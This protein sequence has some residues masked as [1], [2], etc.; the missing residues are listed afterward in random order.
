META[1][2]H[3]RGH[4]GRPFKSHHS[5]M[6]T[7]L[8][9]PAGCQLTALNRTIVGWKR[10]PEPQLVPRPEGFK[11]HHS[12]METFSVGCDEEGRLLL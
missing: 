2:R 3:N 4:S 9:V 7:H 10:G 11:S 6:E 5:G 12:G 1:L 8:T